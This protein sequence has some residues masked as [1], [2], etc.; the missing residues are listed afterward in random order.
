MNNGIKLTTKLSKLTSYGV[1]AEA[2]VVNIIYIKYRR[3]FCRKN[4]CNQVF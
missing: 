1:L 3:L 2:L 4:P